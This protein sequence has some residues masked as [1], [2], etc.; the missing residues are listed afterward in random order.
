MSVNWSTI[1][2]AAGMLAAPNSGTGG[3]FWVGI[4]LM[5][6]VILILVFSGFNI[7]IALMVASFIALIMSIFLTYMDLAS[8]AW[9]LFYIGWILFMLLYVIWSSQKEQA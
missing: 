1:T 7:E 6:W 4:N 2:T 3:W 5:I 9:S 8:W